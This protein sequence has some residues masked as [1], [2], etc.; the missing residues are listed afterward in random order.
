MGWN[1]SEERRGGHKNEV[2]GVDAST[3]WAEARAGL[4][5]QVIVGPHI[6]V[7]CV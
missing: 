1:L 5:F 2:R 4:G 3:E 7:V 6:P